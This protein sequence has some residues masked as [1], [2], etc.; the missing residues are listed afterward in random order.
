MGDRY[1]GTVREDGE[2]ADDQDS[3]L[4]GE[5]YGDEDGIVAG[6]E[7]DGL[8][9]K[10]LLPSVK[11]PRLWQVRVKKGQEKLACMSLMNKSIDYAKKGHPLLIMSVTCSENAD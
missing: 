2:A 9:K 4:S 3:M 7:H 8:T 5:G 11:D 6:G 10:G 1:K